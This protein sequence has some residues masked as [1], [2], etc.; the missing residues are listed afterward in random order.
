[1][2]CAKCVPTT[3]APQRFRRERVSIDQPDAV[4]SPFTALTSV[5]SSLLPR[6]SLSFA[7]GISSV[8]IAV[9]RTHARAALVSTRTHA[10]Y[11]HIHTHHSEA[12]TVFLSRPA[13]T[14][15]PSPSFFS[16]P[17]LFLSLSLH[18]S[19]TH[20]LSC[21]VSLYPHPSGHSSPR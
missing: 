14:V 16:F 8:Y 3:S 9:R 10:P 7:S 6:L 12:Q 2:P 1:M 13:C 17:S 20:A 21:S 11:T 4:V 15:P 18:P 5:A 19:L